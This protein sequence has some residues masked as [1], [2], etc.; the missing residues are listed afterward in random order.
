MD[1]AA[2]MAEVQRCRSEYAE[3]QSAA[4][5]R[6]AGDALELHDAQLLRVRL[7][8]KLQRYREREPSVEEL[9]RHYDAEFD[10]VEEEVRFLREENGLLATGGLEAFE[11]PTVAK[12][13]ANRKPPTVAE[14][15]HGEACELRLLHL[16]A[17]KKA[18]RTRVGE[19]ALKAVK[20]EAKRAVS[21]MKAQEQMLEDLRNRHM[22]AEEHLRDLLVAQAEGEEE[23]AAERERVRALHREALGMREACYVPAALKKEAT[24]LMKLLDHEGGRLKTCRHLRSL[25]SCRRLYQE[26]ASTAPS[27]LPLAG[28]AKAEMEDEFARY[29]ELE[30]SHGIALQR[31]QLGVVRGLQRPHD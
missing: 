18:R 30:E 8:A 7:A 13:C 1:A 10:A 23:L 9:A 12:V 5:E 24:F 6:D 16:Q 22:K 4:A 2:G 25:E 27:L 3:A 19:W 31:L 14:E 20:D 28:R 29:L 11:Q 26:V 21:K 15:L 17:S